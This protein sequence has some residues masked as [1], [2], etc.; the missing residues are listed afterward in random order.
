MYKDDPAAS[1][2]SCR[3][4]LTDLQS[5]KTLHLATTWLKTCEENHS[6][7]LVHDFIP[8]LPNY[9]IDVCPSS[10]GVAAR[11]YKPK[12]GEEAKYLCLSYC[13]GN[14]KQATTT[15]ANLEQHLQEIPIEKLGLT[16]QD[17]IETTRRLGF[18]YLW[19]DALCI[20]QDDDKQKANEV[21]IMSH[22]Y[23]NATAVISAAAASCSSEG[24]LRM[25][26]DME[27]VRSFA[28]PKSA[29]FSFHV[30]FPG[31]HIGTLALVGEAKSYKKHPLDFRAW[32][33]QEQLLS[34]RQLVF[35]SNELLV[36]CRKHRLRPLRDSFLSCCHT[37]VLIDAI[38]TWNWDGFDTMSM[39]SHL[40]LEYSRRKMTDPEDRLHAFEGI[41]QEIQ[42][43]GGK[44]T[45]FG[46]PAFGCGTVAWAA[47]V[48]A[49]VRSSRAPSWSWGCLDTPVWYPIHDNPTQED[50]Y[51]AI[52][53]FSGNEELN[54]L[55]VTACVI[56]GA[57]WTGNHP[58]PNAKVSNH[59]MDRLNPGICHYDL[60]VGFPNP[61]DRYYLRAMRLGSTEVVLILESAGPK[62]YRRAGVY[63]RAIFLGI[64]PTETR[65]IVLI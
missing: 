18:R 35:A 40:I 31:G 65:E 61:R 20:A 54:K 12:R 48:P 50:Q 45:R 8:K 43:V 42:K 62:L 36:W 7:C 6:E 34:A 17:A 58:D 27:I 59:Y 32:E 19:V 55:I 51:K 29:V 21:K 11:L 49:S 38:S 25:D 1:M 10:T 24:F 33:L 23:K 60:T 26:R 14:K 3:P 64:W 2:T 53:R 9:V 28:R 30:E 16:V 44:I 39:W 41:A 63:Q 52:V 13:W 56:E 57:T 22:I 5:D 37:G 15:Q 46:I 47:L 4:P